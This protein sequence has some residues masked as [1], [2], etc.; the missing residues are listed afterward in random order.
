MMP[1][2]SLPMNIY[3][4][5]YINIYDLFFFVLFDCHKPK[6]FAASCRRLKDNL[7]HPLFY[8]LL[9]II[10]VMRFTLYTDTY[11]YL[12]IP[13]TQNTHSQSKSVVVIAMHYCRC[14]RRLSAIYLFVL[15]VELHCGFAYC[16]YKYCFVYMIVSF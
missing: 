11:L 14:M 16:E 8:M 6:A 4:Y 1:R 2:N 5:I 15:C 12:Y 7:W 13:T 3:T 9:I 10:C